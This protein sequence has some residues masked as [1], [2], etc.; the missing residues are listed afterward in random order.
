MAMTGDLKWIENLEDVAFN[1]YPAS[2][3]E[4]LRALRYLTCPTMVQSDS[5]NHAPGVDN[6]GPFFCMNPFSSRCCQHN[7]SMG[8]PY[9]AEN[10]VL[11]SADGGAA[12]LTY[13]DCEARVKVA[14]GQEVILD[15]ATHYPF[16]EDI[17]ITIRG[18]KKNTT[19][20]FPLYLRIP[21]WTPGAH[22]EVNGKTVDCQVKKGLLR[23]R[24][25]WKNGD[26]VKLY[27]PMCL[28]KRVWA[29]NKN[30]VSVDYGPLTLSLRIQERYEKKDSKSTAIGDSHWQ[31]NADASLWP[32]FEI[33]AASPWN[34]A[35][36]PNLKSMKVEKLEWPEDNYPFSLESVPLRVKAKGAQ[37][38][39][40]GMDETGLCQILPDARAPRGKVEDITLIPMGAARLR[41][42]AFP[43]YNYN[44]K[45]NSK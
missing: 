9:Y 31:K 39:S 8:W 33:Y 16:S 40:W 13:S 38:S 14:D 21:S 28:S 45:K 18:L 43:P 37:V 3:T 24:N 10:L 32:T 19:L 1:S 44:V 4:D 25:E 30:S 27:F 35:L 41:I 17:L 2:M 6:G 5:N 26:Q 23:L 22:V 36:V 42:T 20:S 12:V 34:Y 29:L 11:A 7:H 15:E